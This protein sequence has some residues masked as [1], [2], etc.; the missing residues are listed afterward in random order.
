MRKTAQ[1]IS[2]G[3]RGSR[4]FIKIPPHSGQGAAGP[5]PTPCTGSAGHPRIYTCSL[6]QRP[7]R[8][9][10]RKQSL[11][12]PASRGGRG[13]WLSPGRDSPGRAP[14]LSDPPHLAMSGRLGV[15]LACLLPAGLSESK[16]CQA[17]QLPLPPGCSCV[18][19]AGCQPAETHVQLMLRMGLPFVHHQNKA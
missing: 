6:S 13:W 15:A 10:R 1:L 4:G 19:G 11:G 9:P 3:R 17:A 7:R 14:L 12:P 18:G 16:A 2:Q 5:S 8:S